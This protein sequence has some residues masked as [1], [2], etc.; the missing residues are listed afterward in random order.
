MIFCYTTV[1]SCP[2]GHSVFSVF[3]PSPVWDLYFHSCHQID[4]PSAESPGLSSS[5]TDSILE[6]GFAGS[7]HHRSAERGFS[8]RV[9]EAG[10]QLKCAPKVYWALGSMRQPGRDTSWYLHLVAEQ[11]LCS[12]FEYVLIPESLKICEQRFCSPLFS[13]ARWSSLAAF[14]LFNPETMVYIN[15]DF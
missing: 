15:M 6:W 13:N 7:V 5:G 10:A 3:G 1:F 12:L 2:G 4:L 11:Y 8:W 9:L 14:L